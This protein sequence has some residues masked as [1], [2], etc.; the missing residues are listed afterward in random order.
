MLKVGCSEQS[1]EVPFFVKRFGYEPFV[2]CGNFEVHNCLYSRTVSNIVK[3]S[4]L[5]I[6][7]E[8][9]IL[10]GHKKR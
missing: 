1:L 2:G 10:K 8:L 6:K 4:P 7:N 5:S 9:L 3:T